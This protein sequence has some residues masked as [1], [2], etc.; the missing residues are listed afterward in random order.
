M[1]VLNRIN[2]SGDERRE[3]IEALGPL[4]LFSLMLLS[5]WPAPWRNGWGGGHG[6]SKAKPVT[7]IK[8]AVQYTLIAALVVRFGC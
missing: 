5:Y 6:F 1:A 2:K 8:F 3:M 7:L 4:A